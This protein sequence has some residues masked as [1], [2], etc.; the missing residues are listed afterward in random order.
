MMLET[1]VEGMASA[2]ALAKRLRIK[3]SELADVKDD[4][5]IWE[6]F[7]YYIGALCM[8]LALM[9]S[10]NVIVLG[11][12]MTQRRSIL[13]KIQRHTTELI[14]DYVRLPPMEEYIRFSTL[15]AEVGLVSSLHMAKVA[16]EEG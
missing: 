15:S 12:G 10:P 5:E 16:V 6:V 9:V 14:Q 1:C 3:P 11:G 13:K 8:N 4:D 2:G 7:A